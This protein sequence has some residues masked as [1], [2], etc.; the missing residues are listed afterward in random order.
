MPCAEFDVLEHQDLDE[1]VRIAVNSI[2]HGL[3]EGSPLIRD[4]DTVS[5]TLRRSAASFVT[6]KQGEALRGCI[7]SL[8]RRRALA[9][10]V[11]ENAF[12]AA[13]RDPRFPPLTDAELE[14]TAAEVSVLSTPINFDFDGEPDLLA[15]LRPGTDG[16]IIEHDGHKATY[17]PS[18]WEMLPEPRSFIEQLRLKAGI[19]PQVPIADVKIRRYSA[20]YSNSVAL[21]NNTNTD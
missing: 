1:L 9:N 14:L 19:E 3:N 13:F 4:A 10:D 21:T 20:Q 18:V 7:G 5:E 11:A 12:A 2:R 17:L 16:V 15:Q 8:E 6:L